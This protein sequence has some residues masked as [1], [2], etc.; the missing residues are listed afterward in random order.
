MNFNYLFLSVLFF[1]FGPLCVHSA[2]VFP[3]KTYTPLLLQAP[4]H[5]TWQDSSSPPPCTWIKYPNTWPGRFSVSNSLP[6]SPSAEPGP[7][8]GGWWMFDLSIYICTCNV[9]KVLKS[10]ATIR[11]YT[12]FLRPHWYFSIALNVILFLSGRD[13]IFITNKTW[14]V[15]VCQNVVLG[16][17][18][19]TMTTINKNLWNRLKMNF[20][21]SRPAIENPK[22]EVAKLQELQSYR[23]Y[24]DTLTEVTKL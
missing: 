18:N 21:A 13:K 10:T 11:L 20:A 9:T 12:V 3:L 14:I 5:V 2:A 1:H 4:R 8:L 19:I 6:S 15:K 17:I 22:T 7:K 16:K 23:S 24:K